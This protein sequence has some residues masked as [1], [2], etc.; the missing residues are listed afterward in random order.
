[1][2]WTKGNMAREGMTGEN[3]E[4][5]KVN[6]EE[7]GKENKGRKGEK[8]K[9]VLYRVNH[10]NY[11]MLACLLY[12]LFNPFPGNGFW[13]RLPA[14]GGGGVKY[15][16]GISRVLEHIARKFQRLPL[17]FRCHAF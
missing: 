5:G 11:V 8:R 14:T 12:A 10:H 2:Q 3:S 9:K 1:M 17:H 13:R 16:P 4:E 7:R 15:P 6:G